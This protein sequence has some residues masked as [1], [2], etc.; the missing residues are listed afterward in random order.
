[1]VACSQIPKEAYYNR[2]EPESLIDVSSEVVN[3]KIQSPA[4]VEEIT[5]WINRD[6]PTRAE[7]SCPE[8]DFA[9]LAGKRKRAASV[10][11][12]REIHVGV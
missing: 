12:A 6:Q 4:S 8:S 7:I 9:L 2:G 3:L 1:M 11:R 10:R 5:S